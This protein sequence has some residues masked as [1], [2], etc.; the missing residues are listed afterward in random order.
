VGHEEAVGASVRSYL[1]DESS[2]ESTTTPTIKFRRESAGDQR[3]SLQI[4]KET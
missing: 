1:S 2:L 4:I 3:L